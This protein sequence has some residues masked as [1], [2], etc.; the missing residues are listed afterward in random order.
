MSYRAY[1]KNPYESPIPTYQWTK[2]LF[3]YNLSNLLFIF[4]ITDPNAKE[5]AK[6]TTLYLAKLLA[7]L[8]HILTCIPVGTK[9]INF[10]ICLLILAA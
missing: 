9:S 6:L 8:S 7:D 3:E 10:L 1:E 4:P 2:D 5:F